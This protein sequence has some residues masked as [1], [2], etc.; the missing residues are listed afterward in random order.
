MV[1]A[2]NVEQ[3]VRLA[4]SEGLEAV[5]DDIAGDN[6]HIPVKAEQINAID[7]VSGARDDVNYSTALN[8]GT[9]YD[10]SNPTTSEIQAVIDAKNAA[11][12]REN[13]NIN[14]TLAVV[15][16]ITG[17]SSSNTTPITAS[18]INAITGVSGARDGVDYT[19]ALDD[20]VYVDQ[21]NPTVSEIQAVV[22]T[23]NARID[24]INADIDGFSATV[25]DV[26]GNENEI[27]ATASQI[28]AI[29]GVSGARDDVD[30]TTALNNALYSDKANPTAEEIQ[31]VIDIEN[32]NIDRTLAVVE[33]ILGNE[34]AIPVTASEI[35]ALSGVS[36]ARDGVDY[37][38]A[39]NNATYNDESNPTAEE[40]QAV[41]DA[42]NAKIDESSE[43]DIDLTEEP[44][45]TLDG[46]SGVRDDVD[47]STA[48]D[49]AVYVDE[50]NPTA[51]EI[52]AVVD[53]TN[54]NI[55]RIKAN[56]DG[57]EAVIEDITG[58]EDETPATAE[59]I[60]GID[61]VTGARDNVDYSTTLNNTI[62]DP[63]NLTP[64]EIQAVVDTEN[65]NIDR[66]N[67]DI[68][69][70]EAVVEDILGNEDE[71]P[72]S[73]TQIN[74]IDGVTGA[75]EG[76]DYST[77]LGNA[78]IENP[79]N[80]TAEEIQAVID[81]KNA[82]IDRDEIVEDTDNGESI[83][84]SIE[85]DSINT[86]EVTATVGDTVTID[87]L[88]NDTGDF[89]IDSLVLVIPKKLET[90]AVLSNNGKTLT[91]RNEGV[92]T[93]EENNLL[94]FT[95]EEN[96]TSKPSDIR[97]L[98]SNVTG[99]QT[100]KTNVSLNM[101]V[102]AGVSVE[103]GEGYQT[104]D[105]VPVLNGLWAFMAMIFAGLFGMFFARKEEK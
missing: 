46:A 103:E 102:V 19:T 21:N 82:T 57:N 91:V 33:D 60:N 54:A 39:L 61:G 5:I 27:P 49:N 41:I 100:S 44:L 63:D 4:D 67:A 68:G 3:T 8:N 55:D 97:Y 86:L 75:R 52:Q 58:N 15:E 104:S 78:P 65:A 76:I 1:T 94:T 90:K 93:V 72:A 89:E 20:A 18:Q 11:I 70:K 24:R 62:E 74:A 16:E 56:K 36:G 13:A 84:S 81:T 99:E 73:A 30:Y 6:N 31:A 83:E 53:A 10:E 32:S 35:N 92:W 25:E 26:L 34:D 59:Q 51:S 50:N 101:Q 42:E 95:P 29:D 22:D 71:T 105:S 79:E 28:N 87:V 43:E 48:L 88:E 37:S 96:F 69:G 23:E 98:I 17:D 85:E 7:G 9:Y 66:E 2:V 38:T 45:N 14:G 47:Y 12:D 64:T 40:I 77:A 80:P